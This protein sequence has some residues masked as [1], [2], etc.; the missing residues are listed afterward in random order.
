M[1][2]V[3]LMELAAVQ[4]STQG[5]CLL[6]HQWEKLFRFGLGEGISRSIRRLLESAHTGMPPDKVIRAGSADKFRGNCFI[7]GAIKVEPPAMDSR[8]VSMAPWPGDGL[9]PTK[10]AAGSEGHPV[11][12]GGKPLGVEP[13]IDFC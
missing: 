6:S 13:E 10:S 5:G 2:L 9:I 11:S 8:L 3:K 7:A 4:G 12:K 1:S